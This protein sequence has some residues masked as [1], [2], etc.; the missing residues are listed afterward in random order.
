[1]KG[2]IFFVTVLFLAIS[3]FSEA[4]ISAGGYPRDVESLKS[5]TIPATKLPKVDNEILLKSSIARYNQADVLK[6]FQFAETFDVDIT[7][8]KGG[9]W[10]KSADGYNIW[11]CRIQSE[12][13]YSINLIFEPFR[14][15]EGARLFIYNSD[16]THITGAFTSM[17]NKPFNSLAVS[18]VSGDD[19][20][21]QYEEP[22][23]PDFEGELG[24][25]K[26]NHDF[27]GILADENGR[28]PL[29]LSGTCNV[30]INCE[31]GQSWSEIKN[32]ICRIIIAGSEVCTGT[33]LNNAREDKKPYL[34][35][36]NHCF[37]NHVNGMQNSVFLFN[38]ESPYCGALD[39]HVN[40]SISG[41]VLKASF[42]SL[43][44]SLVELTTVPPPEYRP[45]FAGWDRSGN[46]PDSVA[47][48]H[49][50]LGDIKKISL[51][52]NNPIIATFRNDFKKLA[53]WKT[54]TWEFGTT[55]NGS[56]GAPYFNQDKRLIGTLTGGQASCSNSVNDYFERF[57]LSWNY[58][59]D[60]SKQLKCWLDPDNTGINYLDG[61]KPYSGEQL[62]DAF[63]NLVEGD[64]PVLKPMYDEATNFLGFWA[65]TNTAGITEYAERFSI[66]GDEKLTALSIGV[67][68][69]I[70]KNASGKGQ[71][72]VN[73][74]NGAQF[75][76]TKI[77]SK[78]Y[79]LVGLVKDAMNYLEFDQVIEPAD[80]FFVAIGLEGVLQDE[81]FA[82]L[83]AFREN[84]NSMY[85]KKNGSWV[86]FKQATDTLSASM[87]FELVA[88]NVKGT[89]NDTPYIASP[90][91]IKLYP[92]PATSSVWLETS[93][94]VKKDNISVFNLLGAEIS[95]NITQDGLKRFSIDFR[96]N[97]A[98]IYF[99]RVGNSGNPVSKKVSFLPY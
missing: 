84:Y 6:P 36:A 53:F 83:T 5:G 60:S 20:I 37:K 61:F 18:P 34:L 54:L 29:G 69:N 81:T 76:E 99:V 57:D 55:E 96:G 23:E 90:M 51:D 7:L 26:V 93:E 66:N 63:T 72:T 65:G 11:Q 70:L 35:T 44:F 91:E 2:L 74:Y 42:D 78:S 48:I 82:V 62:C 98:G 39:G 50:P 4:Q 31:L 64:S 45:Y 32:S 59:P 41:A 30:D 94:I 95:V 56:S 85:Y 15:P 80:T 1:M 67:A 86:N 16:R 77:Y 22:A 46:I 92:N 38:Y 71:L 75:P 3:Y 73:I 19:I 40:N 8:Q 89:S 68:R 17:N 49:H 10:S 14:L 24:I 79:T 9:L 88:C 47:S 43:D 13:A 12:G 58:L 97:P 52:Y 27:A 87:A 28:R 33:L 25:V 21:V